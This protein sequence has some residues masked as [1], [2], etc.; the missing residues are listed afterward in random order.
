MGVGIED[1]LLR[2]FFVSEAQVAIF[3]GRG[4]LQSWLDFERAL[5]ASQAD[6][7][8]IPADAAAAIA[9][10]CDARLYDL[11]AL[12]AETDATEHPLIA[13]VDA[14][15]AQVGPWGR[16]VHLGATTQ[17]VMDTGATIQLRASLAVLA[18]D[19]AAAGDLLADLAARHRDSLQVGRTHGQPAV[20]ITFG[21]K[22]AGWLD[23]LTRLLAGWRA[24]GT[25][26]LVVECGGAA[27]SMAG[28]GPQALAVQ[29]GVARRLGLGEPVV[30]WHAARDRW[31]SLADA[32][33][34]LA[35]FGERVARELIHLQ[36]AE[37][38]EVTDASGDRHVGSSTMPQ[39]R[40]PHAA[41][42][43]VAKARV[44]YGLA[45]ALAGGLA[46]EHERDMGPWGAEWALIPELM[47]L[48][49][50]IGEGLLRLFRRLSVDT[51]RMRENMR[52]VEQQ[53]CA[54]AV[55]LLLAP[56]IGRKEA[57]DRLMLHARAVGGAP[58]AERLLGDAVVRQ[59]LSEAEI[60]RAMT[61]ESHVGL[62]NGLVSRAVEAW[63]PVR[64]EAVQLAG[65][66]A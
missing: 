8:L 3:A 7:G 5:A 17:D 66:W 39:K 57:H 53:I 2:G 40:N 65:E 23:E 58:L 63:G 36:A 6:L 49:G 62:A 18:R 24:L 46:H 44:A 10:A 21:L 48:A 50:G 41:E 43:M 33:V 20:P 34:R 60:R 13:M 26:V 55:L 45:G 54:E 19:L 37:F 27:G 38:G 15:E 52:R 12:R 25:R 64:D 59:H 30:P 29:A 11:A 61:P 1:D 47:V 16:F 28:Y 31:A 4:R 22:A 51:D 9:A 35:G 32:A 14:L 42:M 56:K